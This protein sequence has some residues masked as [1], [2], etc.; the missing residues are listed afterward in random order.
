MADLVVEDGTGL[1]NADAF[2]DEDF[3]D[4][5]CTDRDISDWLDGEGDGKA[6]IRRAT[7]FLCNAYDWKGSRRRGRLQ[8]LV[9][10]RID[11]EDE[12]GE[13]V[14]PSSVPQEV[15]YACCELS[16]YE[17]ANPGALSPAVIAADRIKR[18]K[19]GPLETEYA[20][21]ALSPLDLRPVLTLVNDMLSGLVDTGSL[22]SLSGTAVR[23]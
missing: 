13:A 15:L 3:V 8:S 4:Q 21:S 11:V 6:A 23:V 17:R 12:E 22:N 1:A 2:V 18:E 19:I 14:D 5:Y 16:A 7:Q 10:P 9:F 20:I